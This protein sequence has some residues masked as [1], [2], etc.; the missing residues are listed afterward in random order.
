MGELSFLLLIS[1]DVGIIRH[2]VQDFF[3]VT[4]TKADAPCAESN[5]R[6][7]ALAQP[8]ISSAWRNAQSFRH[9]SY[10]QQ[11]FQLASK[12]IAGPFSTSL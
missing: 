1:Q 11:F 8:V 6:K 2:L 7:A 9:F 3:E 4:F 10:C 12:F 5:A